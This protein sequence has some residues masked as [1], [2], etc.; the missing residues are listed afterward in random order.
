MHLLLDCLYVLGGALLLP[1]WLYKLPQ[2]PRYRAGLLERLGRSPELPP[3]PKRLWIHCASVGEAAIPRRLV[4]ELAERHPNWETVFSTNT[5]TGAARL[6]EL[7]PE[8]TVFYMPLDLSLAAWS[9]LQ[10][11][12]PDV[13]VLVEL[14]LW[15]NFVDA[16]RR[17]GV[18]VAIINGRI[19]AGSRAMLG[20]LGRL[21]GRL[22][23]AVSVCCA[24]SADDAEGFA[25]AGMPPERVF[26][27]GMLKCD[28]LSV[29]ADASKLRHLHEL[30]AIDPR[31][32]VLVAG[33]THRGE[34]VAVATAYRDLKRDRRDLRLIIAPRHV[35]RAGE[36]LAAVRA[37]GLPVAAKTDLEAGR[38]TASGDEVIVVDTIGDLVD[39]YALATCVFVGRSLVPPGGGQNVM[40]PAALGKPVL[41][42][43]HMANFAPEMRMLRDAGAA[44][45]V[46]SRAELARQV[47]HL[48]AEP[49]EVE[50]M[51]R[52]GRRTITDS[53]GATRRTMER[54]EPLL[55]SAR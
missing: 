55:K 41:V 30:F 35:E 2:A 20:L 13:V 1:Y 34:E 43:P 16:C 27:C 14:E 11:I 3:E 6:R 15:P 26:E 40:E 32:A 49:A 23:D 51:G 52:A 10:R 8:S 29:E 22:W 38:A 44:V 33:S 7:Y 9:A 25:A 18:P 36:V 12:R 53:R 47:A 4:A 50:R 39:C 31:S 54:L 21:W 42:G 48:L 5:D 45:V 28:G 19:G 37:R 17:R 46:R 24:R